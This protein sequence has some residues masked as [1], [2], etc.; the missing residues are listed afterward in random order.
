MQASP[1][2]SHSYMGKGGDQCLEDPWFWFLWSCSAGL[3]SQRKE[4]QVG[5]Q[6]SL[7]LPRGT[8]LQT[9]KGGNVSGWRTLW[10]RNTELG[11]VSLGRREEMTEAVDKWPLHISSG[12]NTSSFLYLVWSVGSQGEDPVFTGDHWSPRQAA[13]E[14]TVR[15]GHRTWLKNVKDFLQS[16]QDKVPI[17]TGLQTQTF[18]PREPESDAGRQT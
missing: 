14:A 9:S 11:A 13:S 7:G 8:R 4:R 10:K 1:W 17:P 3:G 6:T 2:L 16:G 12:L 15:Q 5:H 18:Q